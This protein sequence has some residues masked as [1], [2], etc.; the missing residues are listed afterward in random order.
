M[1]LI[2]TLPYVLALGALNNCTCGGDDVGALPGDLEGRFCAPDTGGGLGRVEVSVVRASDSQAFPDK[3]VV[4]D[5]DGNFKIEQ[6]APATYVVTGTFGPTIREATVTVESDEKTTFVDPAC[7]PPPPPPPPTGGTVSGRECDAA[8]GAWLAFAQAWLSPPNS[9][10]EVLFQAVTDVDGNFNFINVTP[11]TYDLHLAK[12]LYSRDIPNVVV[13][14]AMNT[15]IPSPT[16]CEPTALGSLEGRVCQDGVGWLS[17]G[18]ASISVAGGNTLTATTDADGRFTITDVPPGQYTVRVTKDLFFRSWQVTVNSG[19]ATQVPSPASCDVPVGAGTVTGRVCAPDGQT[20]LAGARVFVGDPNSPTTETSTDG[21]G[22]FTL[23][24]VPEGSITIQVQKNSFTATY[25]VTVTNGLTTVVPEE[26]CAVIPTMTRV[27]VVSGR[28][29]N[30]RCVLT[31]QTDPLAS[32]TGH[33]CNIP[34][35]GLDTSRV[36]SLDGLSPQWASSLLGNYAAMSMYDIIFFNCGVDDARATA[37]PNTATYA[38]NLRRFVEQG[39]S[40]YA[41]DWAAPLIELAFPEFITW[42]GGTPTADNVEQ[43]KVGTVQTLTANVVD[44]GIR[45]ALGQQTVNLSF[46][47]PAWVAMKSTAPATQTYIRGNAERSQGF[48][49]TAQMANIPF[50]VGFDVGQGRVIFTSFH[51]ERNV[52]PDMVAVLNL[53]VFEL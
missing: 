48:F 18:T 37:N 49:G 53:L 28:Y 34:G 8:A 10:N 11:G 39:G 9:I 27:A 16:S 17:G 33:E 21:D 2:R 43:A 31:G 40:V 30:V 47:L 19:P 22:R 7:R 51:Q 38:A 12:D 24:G 14:E 5:N 29:D 45:A 4:G 35:L 50:T 20:W 15:A 46:D 1:R 13:V 42:Q 23:T 26:M 6:L 44:P 32:Q 25:T 52:T 41:S 3:S 36:T